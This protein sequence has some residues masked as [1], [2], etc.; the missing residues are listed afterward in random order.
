MNIWIV[1]TG[2]S[3][4]QLKTDEHW[5]DWYE[6]TPVKRNCY[7]LPFKP[8]QIIEDSD[9]PHRI[10]PRVL[11]MVY[12]A[13]PDEVWECLEFPLL[14]QFTAQLRGKTIDKIILL[15]TD[16]TNRF[17]EDQQEDRRCP[18]W[19]DTCSLKPILERY[20]QEKQEFINVELI[21]LIL[22]PRQNKPGLDDWNH[23]L[24]IVQTTFSEEI[25]FKPDTVYVSHQAGTPAIS[26]AVQFVSLAQFE[27]KVTFLVSNEY[28]SSLTVFIPS[29]KYLQEFQREKAKKLLERHDYFGVQQLFGSYL[30]SEEQNLLEAAIKW[31]Q[32]EFQKF[33]DELKICSNQNLNTE[34]QERT[35]ESNWWWSAYESAYLAVIRLVQKNTVEAMFH[36]F[37][38]VEGAIGYWS[39]QEY[40]GDI[41]DRKGKP[42]AILRSPSKLPNYLIKELEES[43]NSEMGLYGERLFKL[44]RESKPE[45]KEHDDLKAIWQS[46]K[47]KRNDQFHQLLGLDEKEIF[48]AWGRA[49]QRSWEARLLNCLKL[50]TNQNHF[51]SIKKASLM[52]KVHEELEKAIAQHER[53]EPTL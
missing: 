43:K 17:N 23:V 53:N 51:I 35:K 26:S 47:K 21:P 32:A 37:R 44:F 36:S 29:S 11:G 10:A 48:Q 13:Q 20:F 9:E 39:K 22:S 49:N 46:A 15:L 14:H 19:Q 28:D 25:K 31:N 5:H 24:K 12:E 34:A 18:Y 38:A 52:F 3:D 1:T 27:K 7:N 40:P 42:V 33:A 50:I 2:S 4:V 16:Q 8:I 45:F 41:V 30:K 6:R